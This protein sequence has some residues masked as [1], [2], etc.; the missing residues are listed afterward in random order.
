MTPEISAVYEIPCPVSARGRWLLKHQT[1]FG[2]ARIVIRCSAVVTAA[3][4]LTLD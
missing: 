4:V 1:A 3:I 2:A